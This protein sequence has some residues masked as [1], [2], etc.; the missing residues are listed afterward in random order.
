MFAKTY[1]TCWRI[2][3]HHYLRRV[4]I[5]YEFGRIRGCCKPNNYSIM[6]LVVSSLFLK[7]VSKLF[8]LHRQLFASLGGVVAR[9]VAARRA[10]NGAVRPLFLSWQ[11]VARFNLTASTVVYRKHELVEGC[12]AHRKVRFQRTNRIIIRRYYIVTMF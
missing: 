3:T 2:V 6:F 5:E 7:H 12:A 10:A 11:W 1:T 4:V 9:T 8:L